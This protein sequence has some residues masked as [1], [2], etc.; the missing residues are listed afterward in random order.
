MKIEPSAKALIVKDNKL[1]LLRY[2]DTTYGLGTWY[3]LPGG[4]QK[5]GE[6]LSET[7]ARECGEE[8]SARIEV[9]PL[10]YVREYIH[11]NHALAGE[12]RDQ[13]KIEFMFRCTL[14]SDP[15]ST[16]SDDDQVAIEWRNLSDLKDANIFPTGLKQVASDL[17]SDLRHLVPIYWGDVL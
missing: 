11:R 14:L 1:L 8:I 9:G 12:G 15:S 16:G 5:Y 13:H 3:S 7:L 4:R 10:L 17:S 2:D 6:P